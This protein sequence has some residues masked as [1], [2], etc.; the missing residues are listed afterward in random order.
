MEMVVAVDEESDELTH[1]ANGIYLGD[2]PVPGSLPPGK[3]E[4]M[5]PLV[6][7]GDMDRAVCGG[8]ETAVDTDLSTGGDE[9][10]DPAAAVGIGDVI[11]AAR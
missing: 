1:P 9:F 7:E 5:T 4:V 11:G 6:S 2:H 10:E 8:R 3:V